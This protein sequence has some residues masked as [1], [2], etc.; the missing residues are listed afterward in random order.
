MPE[1]TPALPLLNWT[2]ISLRPEGQHHALRYANKAYGASVFECSPIRLQALAADDE[3][4]TACACDI[5]IATSPTAVKFAAQSNAFSI[6][7]NT[8]WYGV[9]PSTASALKKLGV[10]RVDY[11]HDQQTSEGLLRLASLHVL[12]SKSVGVLTAPGGRNLIAPTLEARGAQLCV[13]EVY[14]RVAVSISHDAIK[15]LTQVQ[16]PAAVFCTSHEVFLALW[17]ALNNDARECLKRYRWVLSGERL[18]ALL[19]AHGIASALVC[20]TAVPQIM[21][22]MLVDDVQAQRMR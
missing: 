14:S 9:G 18:A 1:M 15:A 19:A 7:K 17:Q 13:A 22:K 12:A 16:M 20:H 5:V 4:R 3:I 10:A 2:C 8:Q 21:L 6:Q 11:P